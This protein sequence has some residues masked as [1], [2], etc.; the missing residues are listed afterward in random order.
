VPKFE[1][2]IPDHELPIKRGD[3][4]T[5]PKGTLV[6]NVRTG[7]TIAGRTYKVKV[8]HFISGMTHD[9]VKIPPKVCWAGS[10]GYWS[11]VDINDIPEAN[12]A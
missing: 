5:I 6:K 3:T 1:G 10:G 8:D 12:N 7:V 4:V 9:Q 11:E 2:Y